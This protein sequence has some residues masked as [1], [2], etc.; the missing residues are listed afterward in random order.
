MLYFIDAFYG[1][2]QI[3]MFQPDEEKTAF[4]TP[5]GLYCYKVMPFGLK[6]VRAIYQRLMT[7]IFKPLISQTMEVYIND[8]VVKSKTRSEHTLQL[9]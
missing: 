9:E 7:K 1:Y 3:P 8:I 5:H 4:V 6:N 2:H